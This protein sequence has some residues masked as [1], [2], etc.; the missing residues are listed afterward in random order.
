LWP[1]GEKDVDNLG[2]IN[3]PAFTFGGTGDGL[4]DG[5]SDYLKDRRLVILADNDDPGREHAEKKAAAA[6][7]AGATSINVLHFPE[8]PKGGDVS[9]WIASGGTAEQLS[10]RV[11]GAPQWMAAKPEQVDQI[12]DKPSFDTP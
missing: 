2:K 4:P 6:R 5:I 7:A 8:L 3:L 10:D 12:S 11:R 9:D 1:E